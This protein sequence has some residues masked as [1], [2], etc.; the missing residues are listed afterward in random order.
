M[1]Q[2]VYFDLIARLARRALEV[3]AAMRGDMALLLGRVDHVE[4]SLRRRLGNLDDALKQVA[5]ELRAI[6]ARQDR[7]DERVRRLTETS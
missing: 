7:A 1:I 3:Q 5:V 4:R 6:R 2:S